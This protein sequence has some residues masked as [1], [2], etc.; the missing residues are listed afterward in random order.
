MITKILNN[1]LVDRTDNI[2]NFT[3]ALIGAWGVEGNENIQNIYAGRQLITYIYSG[4]TLTNLSVNYP[5]MCIIYYSDET[6]EIKIVGK[7]STVNVSKEIKMA[8][9]IAQNI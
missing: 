1:G 8:I 3:K 7:A 5:A 4:T 9:M 2:A 6:S